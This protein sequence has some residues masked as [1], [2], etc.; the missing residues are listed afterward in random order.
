M[1]AGS[2]TPRH[3]A[4]GCSVPG[5]QEGMGAGARLCPGDAR[6]HRPLVPQSGQG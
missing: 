2:C 1:R 4:R 3:G 6:L 5:L